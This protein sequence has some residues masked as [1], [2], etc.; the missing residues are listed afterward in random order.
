MSFN[1]FL[2][3]TTILAICPLERSMMIDM[4]CESLLFKVVATNQSAIGQLKCGDC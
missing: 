1:H 4:F 2:I 3:L